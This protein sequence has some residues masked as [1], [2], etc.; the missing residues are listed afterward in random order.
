MLFSRLHPLKCLKSAGLFSHLTLSTCRLETAPS[1]GSVGSAAAAAPLQRPASAAGDAMPDASGLS[2]SIMSMLQLNEGQ[3]PSSPPC[4]PT[5]DSRSSSQT[6]QRPPSR[7]GTG[8]LGHQSF[9]SSATQQQQQQQQP[10]GP[11]SSHGHGL[12][13]LAGNGILPPGSSAHSLGPSR[14]QSVASSSRTV[15]PPPPPLQGGPPFGGP[16]GFSPARGLS[17]PGAMSASQPLGS[18]ALPPAFVPRSHVGMGNHGSSNGWG[19]GGGLPGIAHWGAGGQQ[20]GNG[21]GG[22]LGNGLSSLGAQLP[23]NQ[24]PFNVI[25]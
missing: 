11:V 8:P 6:T 4:A 24:A 20:M 3:P 9:L 14:P 10:F 25:L 13:Q 16:P 15:T 21:L 1:L 18:A 2:D 5:A 19:A 23:G 12:Q 22:G 7:P 17:G